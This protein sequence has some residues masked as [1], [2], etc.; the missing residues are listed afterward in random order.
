MSTARKTGRNDVSS[1]RIIQARTKRNERL[2]TT[3][4]RFD[5]P[6]S[7]LETLDTTYDGV[8]EKLELDGWASIGL[9]GF[10]SGEGDLLSA[11]EE[12]RRATLEPSV[13]S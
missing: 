10:G 1:T 8:S 12:L 3:A 5:L 13:S 9:Q 6:M 11:L 4:I 2:D 7:A